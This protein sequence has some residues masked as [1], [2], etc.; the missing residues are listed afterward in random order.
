MKLSIILPTYNERENILQLIK[1]INEVLSSDK[2]N[3]DITV[4][5]DNSP[6][7]TG[8]VVKN[9]SK[10][11][12][13]VKCIIRYNEKG[14][15][16]AIKEGIRNTSGDLIAIL[17]TDF[18]HPPKVIRKLLSNLNGNHMVVASRYVHNGSMDA[19]FHKYLGSFILNKAIQRIMN[20]DIKDLTGGFL[21]VKR[22]ALQN[23]DLDKI[24]QGYG[25]FCFRLL[26]VFKKEGRKIKEIPFRYAI[27]RYGKSK[28]SLLRTG[29]T[30][31]YKALE[32]KR[33]L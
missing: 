10:K 12:P 15:A 2:I 16:S 9:F 28:T 30:Y 24:F 4:V 18:S 6:D 19:P 31:L 5:D 22:E 7:G 21:I 23:L 20:I 26:Y 11:H 14:L 13:K 17:D 29:L 3:Y 25:D 32:A 33:E 8:K 27:R 1:E